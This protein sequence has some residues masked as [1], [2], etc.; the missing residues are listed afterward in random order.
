MIFLWLFIFGFCFWQ[1]G[2]LCTFCLEM[3]LWCVS[4]YGHIGVK[5]CIFSRVFFSLKV[6]LLEF[7]IRCAEYLDAY[8]CSY[9]CWLRSFV[10]SLCIC[11]FF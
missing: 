4:Y 8:F 5:I 6:D 7:A 11:Y 2:V 1:G 3:F 10:W 9:G